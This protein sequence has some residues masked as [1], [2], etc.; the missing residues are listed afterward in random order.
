MQKRIKKILDAEI[1]KLL[2]DSAKVWL[3][4]NLTEPRKISLHIVESKKKEE[5]WLIVDN[6]SD[7]RIAYNER[8]N[9]FGLVGSLNISQHKPYKYCSEAEETFIGYYGD[10]W[11]TLDAM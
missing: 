8:K 1:G 7:Y 2:E 5:F 11:E 9:M 4:Q 3:L 6:T 10:L